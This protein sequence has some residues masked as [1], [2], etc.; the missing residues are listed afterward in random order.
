MKMM[1]SPGL[2]TLC[3]ITLISACTTTPY[4]RGKTPAINGI[5]NI[6][7]EPKAGINLYLSLDS[8]D[9]NCNKAIQTTVSNQQGEFHF[10][11]I[12]EQMA[13][14]PL[15]TYYLNEWL[16]CAEIYGSKQMIYS[17][18]YYGQGSVSGTVD[19]IC[20]NHSKLSK[21]LTCRNQS[22]RSN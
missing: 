13:Y 6:N 15:M 20:D 14:T 3:L 8:K 4:S 11:A 10:T 5:L 2:L 12:K 9:R 19:L 21:Q 17:D 22:A 18:N 7:S 16:I 1:N